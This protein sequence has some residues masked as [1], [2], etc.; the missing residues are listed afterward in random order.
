MQTQEKILAVDDDPNNVAI[1]QELLEDDYDLKVATTGEQA[2]EIV[3]DFQP[4]VVLVD[5]MM[6]GMDGYQVCRRLREDA[7][8]KHTKII[9]V[10]ARAMVSERLKGY[11]AGADDYITKPFDG[12][13]FLA[14]VRVHLRLKHAE[15][16][17]HI[18]N[19]VTI[20]AM[21]TLSAPV[22]VARKIICEIDDGVFGK[23][24]PELHH[25]LETA[26]WCLD[27]LERIINSFLDIEKLYMDPVQLE[28]SEF[29]MQSVVREVVDAL[30][31]Q[32]ALKDIA[33]DI[34]MPGEELPV[35]A[36]RDS[37]SRILDN[38]IGEI[39]RVTCAGNGIR[40]RVKDL[41]DKV[42]VDIEGNEL[43]TEVGS[44]DDL[45]NPFERTQT[46]VPS[47]GHGGGL[48]LAVARELAELHGGRIQV[49]ERPDGSKVFGFEIP[50]CDRS[51]TTEQPVLSKVGCNSGADE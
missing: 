50:I 41:Q 42:G 51:E 9:M 8:L 32:A 48:G 37:I 19:E 12:D 6:P 7:T 4:D 35:N 29:S 14:K 23:I 31:P 1:L 24:D 36:D 16:I 18:R 28:P 3:Q 17:D 2:L 45:F 34:D 20:A 47:G 43:C 46:H 39:I 40:V 21:E 13:E 33:L 26:N 5:I 49:D 11:E 44:I 10:S 15:D 38:L 25:Q 22:V 27:D 30:E